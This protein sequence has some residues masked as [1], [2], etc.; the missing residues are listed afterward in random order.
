MFVELLE[1]P[2]SVEFMVP[3]VISHIMPLEHEEVD[4]SAVRGGRNKF[5]LSSE[6]TLDLHCPNKKMFRQTVGSY[7]KRRCPDPYCGCTRRHEG[8]RG[9]S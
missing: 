3:A 6:A 1:A 7:L 4:H 8:G 9:I 5:L 2:S